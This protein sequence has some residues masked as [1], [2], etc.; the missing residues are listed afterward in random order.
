MIHFLSHFT[1]AFHNE[2]NVADALRWYGYEVRCYQVTDPHDRP[3]CNGNLSVGPG[4]VVFTSVPQS[5]SLA[6]LRRY[7]A[8]GAYLSC[9]YWDWLWGLGNRD[10][11][12]TPAL[13]LMDVIFSTDGFDDAE[14][15]ARGI[16]CRYY[17]PQGAMPEDRMLPPRM[18]TPQ[19]DVV[20]IGHLDGYPLRGEMRRRLSARWNFAVY[21]DYDNANRRVWGRELTFILQNAKIAVGINYR[22][23]VPGY[24][25]DRIYVTLNNGGFYLGQFVPGIDRYFKAGV[26]CDFFAGLDEMEDKCRYWLA[27]DLERERCRRAGYALVRDRDTYVH[28]VGELLEAWR[29]LGLVR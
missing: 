2:K 26:H 9:W 18:G 8:A 10:A 15:R 21:G 16:N 6:D 11:E 14:Y 19:H 3:G 5:M 25:S 4:D 27:H 22:D 23:D 13:K 1:P 29:R 24:W 12:Y 20:F 7:K 28:R 17:L